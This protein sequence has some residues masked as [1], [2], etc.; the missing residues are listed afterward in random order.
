M[1]QL[2]LPQRRK[3]VTY[4]AQRNRYILRRKVEGKYK[5]VATF[6]NLFEANAASLCF[7][8]TFGQ[9][10]YIYYRGIP[11]PESGREGRDETPK[12][13]VSNLDSLPKSIEVKVCRRI[14]DKISQS[15]F[16]PQVKDQ[17]I[18]FSSLLRFD[19]SPRRLDSQILN[20]LL[21]SY[22]K[23][24]RFLIPKYVSRGSSYSNRSNVSKEYS[25][26]T[27]PK[28]T[29]TATLTNK[30]LIGKLIMHKKDKH[31]REIKFLDKQQGFSSEGVSW[32]I[33]SLDN[34]TLSWAGEELAARKDVNIDEL[35]T[36]GISCTNGRLWHGLTQ[37]PSEVR[38]NGLL[39][40]ESVAD[41]DMGKSQ[42]AILSA[43]FMKDAEEKRRFQGLI[44]DGT[45]YSRMG[46]AMELDAE[47]LA[48]WNRN[49]KNKK[50]QITTTKQFLNKCLMGHQGNDWHGTRQLKREFP[51]A[52]KSIISYKWKCDKGDG[53][54][55]GTQMF[56]GK[57]QGV[58]ASIIAD[59]AKK[60]MELD[61]PC[62][63][64]F[65]GMLVPR[66]QAETVQGFFAEV[67][68]KRLE[69][70]PEPTVETAGYETFDSMC[71]GF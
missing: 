36:R 53:E 60:C 18:Y 46:L 70:A 24:S 40:G 57:L 25:Y 19:G 16:S 62:V 59:V 28:E 58:E 50:D 3:G 23:V 49:P 15:T 26:T 55:N 38:L 67:L 7:G 22:Q 65:D 11:N 39:R 31:R 34:F 43:T 10:S 52:M 5:R 68:S 63:S 6:K 47:N 61:I 71:A 37:L 14:Y 9:T 29:I 51:I 44:L 17:A 27:I 33:E 32:I 66:S 1:D 13:E 69:F 42:L 12:G 56:A 48:K 4:L 30:T 45:I 2:R 64:I 20:H 41:V 8:D 21:R 35:R 54:K